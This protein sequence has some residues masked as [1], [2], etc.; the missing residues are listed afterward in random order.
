MEQNLAQSGSAATRERGRR[1][2]EC[3]L[4]VE[5]DAVQRTMTLATKRPTN[6]MTAYQKSIERWVFVAFV[7]LLVALFVIT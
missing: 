3:S 1:S 2:G 4:R 5:R 7:M 6:K